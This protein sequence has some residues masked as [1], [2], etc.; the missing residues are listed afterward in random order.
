MN[1]GGHLVQLSA[2]SRDNFKVSTSYSGPSMK[3]P[4]PL[5]TSVLNSS[6]SKNIF[7]ASTWKF[8]T[9]KLWLLLIT[10]WLCI[11]QKTLVPFS[12]SPLGTTRSLFSALFPPQ[13]KPNLANVSFHVVCSIS[14]PIL[15]ALHWTHFVNF[16]LKQ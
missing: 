3:I 16:F 7:H 10:C 11:S 14:L 5:W 1:S 8:S 2:K 4:Q 15:V 6:Y 12:N 9:C 13:N